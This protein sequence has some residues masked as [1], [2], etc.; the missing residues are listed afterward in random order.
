MRKA[1]KL[2]KGDV[3]GGCVKK[4]EHT[5]SGKIMAKKVNVSKVYHDMQHF[6]YLSAIQ[7][8]ITCIFRLTLLCLL[9][10]LVIRLS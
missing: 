3:R 5:P 9:S 6:L 8:S 2:Q 1:K 4:V 10:D 7:Y